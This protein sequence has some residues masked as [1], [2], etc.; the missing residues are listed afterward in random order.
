LPHLPSQNADQG[1]VKTMGTNDGLDAESIFN[2]PSFGYNFDDLV[3]LPGHATCNVN[4]VNLTTRFSR[5]VTVSNP[6]VSAPMDSVTEAPMAIAMA[7]L[8]GIGVIHNKCSAVEQARQ[9]SKVKS[10]RNG[11]IMDPFVLSPNHTVQDVDKITQAHGIKTVLIADGGSMG[12]KLLGI[13]TSRDIDHLTDR[14]VPLAKVMTPRE[15]MIVAKESDGGRSGLSLSDANVKL[16]ESKKGKLPV[17]NETS[18]LVAMVSRKNL[19]KS[20]D[21]PLASQD[22]NKQLLVAAACSPNIDSLETCDRVKQLVEA[23]VDVI[24]LDSSQGSSSQQIAFLKKVK[25]DYPNLDIVCGNVVTPRQAKPLLDAGADGLR[26]GMGC[27]SL[28]SGSEVVAVGR[29]QGSAV[30]HVARFCKETNSQVPVIADGGVQNSDHAAM[31]LTLGA[32]TVMCGSLFAATEESPGESFFH[33]GMRLKSYRGVGAFDVMPNAEASATTS[34]GADAEATQSVGCAVVDRGSVN[35]LLPYL[36][37]GVQ[38][39]LRRLGVASVPQLH[40]AL[41]SYNTRLHI[42]TPGAYGSAGAGASVNAVF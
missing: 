29:P 6:F 2:T 24:V 19:K 1:F 40:E 7:L 42:R 10:F 39:N 5:N 27:S 30:Y 8:G 38:A 20:R 14:T 21:F 33:N 34:V 16:R 11:F 22:A 36:L 4:D 25:F 18:E 41:Y 13:V 32:S 17:V 3:A 28:F 26:V 23:G 37:Q 35:S 12:S 15:N 31:A 9:V